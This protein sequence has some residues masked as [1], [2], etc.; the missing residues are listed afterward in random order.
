MRVFSVDTPRQNYA[1]LTTAY[2]SYRSIT[3]YSILRYI[4]YIL[5][6]HSTSAFVVPFRHPIMFL[7][8]CAHGKAATPVIA[9]YTL[10]QH[11][12]HVTTCQG[13]LERLH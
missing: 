13:I 10:R 12:G 2:A 9:W 5:A 7:E 3:V 11:R 4:Y 1:V 6:I 8:E